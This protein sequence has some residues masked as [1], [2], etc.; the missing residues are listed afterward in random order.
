M[1]DTGRIAKTGIWIFLGLVIVLQL[2]PFYVT[3]TTALKPR[4]DRSSSW[5]FPQAE[6]AWENFQTAIEDGHVLTAIINTAIVT[7]AATLITCI[8]AVAAA[9]PLARRTTIG[10]KVLLLGIIGFMMIPPLSTLVPLYT[11]L[12][13]LGALNTRWGIVLVVVSTSLPLAIFLYASFMRSLPISVEE[14]ALVDGANRMQIL[15][16][17]V[18]P[19]LKP[20]TATVVIL[21]SVGVWNEYAL[22]NYI[23]TKPDTRMLAPSISTFFSSAGSNFGAAAAASLLALAPV[24]VAY[25]LLQ[26]QFIAG[27]VAGAEK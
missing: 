22:S 25:L 23:L 2:I 10:N 11:L 12:R 8:V 27:M 7:V 16:R 14:A 15:W 24:L 20:V 4:T 21:T 3:V 6:I 13:D 26:R 1:K 19:M 18:V 9:Y 5:L 17:I